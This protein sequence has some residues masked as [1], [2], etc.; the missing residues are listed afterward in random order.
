MELGLAE[1]EHDDWTV[2]TV[3]G[4][5]DIATAPSLRERLHSLLADGRHKLIIDLDDVGFLDS[6]GLGVLVGVLKR[7]RTQGGELRL[8]CTQPRIAKVF[9]ITRL[10]SAFAIF[11]SLDGAVQDGSPS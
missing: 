5:I 2:L 10:D 7:V 11:D 9:E 3:S 6:T 8:I 4:E 1:R